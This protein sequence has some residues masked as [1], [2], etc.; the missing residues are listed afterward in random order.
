MSSPL[1]RVAIITPHPW[2]V[3]HPTNDHILDVLEGLADLQVTE[4]DTGVALGVGQSAPQVLIIAPSLR[5]ADR[6]RT[7]A[8][9]RDLAQGKDADETLDRCRD[10]QAFYT[11]VL[12]LGAPINRASVALRAD[13][14]V[15]FERAGISIIH[16]HDPMHGDLARSS[17]RLWDGIVI[18]TLHELPTTGHLQV[19]TAPLRAKLFE[20][21]DACLVPYQDLAGTVSAIAEGALTNVE[22]APTLSATRPALHAHHQGD[23]T[24]ETTTDTTDTP[25][26]PGN[27]HSRA[28]LVPLVNTSLPTDI[29]FLRGRGDDLFLRGVLK[30]L[31]KHPA[32]DAIGN[33][34]LLE[35]W[36]PS[37]RP[38]VPKALRTGVCVDRP[39]TRREADA[40]YAG[41]AAVVNLPGTPLR[42]L[43][44]ARAAGLVELDGVDIDGTLGGI[45]A[46]IAEVATEGPRAPDATLPSAT[47]I[48]FDMVARWAKMAAHR[49]QPSVRAPLGIKQRECFMDL[50]MHTSHSWDCATDPEALMWAARKVGLTG[51]AVTDH[52]EISGALVC[53]EL[54]DE[55]GL[56][57]IV[58][59]EV[60]TSE[61]E[62]I[63][64]FLTERIEGGLT[65]HETIRQIRK[66]DGI[67]YV[68]HPFDRLHTIPSLALL[69]ESIDE[70]DVFEVYNARLAFEQYNRDALKFARRYN[71]LEG[72]GSDA[73]V[74][75][76]LGTAAVQMPA[77]DDPESFLMAL[78]DAEI[79]RR[80]TSVLMLQGLKLLDSVTGKTKAS[81]AAAHSVATHAPL[82][83]DVDTPLESESDPKADPESD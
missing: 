44:E 58:G 35:R 57:V 79:H 45:S 48:A 65:W 66:Q 68:P 30:A 32:S 69:R 31:A 36:T 71:L 61:G 22:V 2:G 47:D 77:W 12:A 23:A 41:S 21:I 83:P 7:R 15:V 1:E 28:G 82:G 75:Q 43:E 39:K 42:L 55:Y 78:R 60:K 38:H 5:T 17:V 63:G 73:H 54:A 6:R 25:D 64:L 37:H 24:D 19:I 18:A 26:T 76:G 13:L 3:P 62:V 20:N 14:R 10:E 70:I 67:V 81:S 9:I 53:A 51:I 52:N 34:R 33:L 40:I 56:Q 49:R 8:A 27:P 50:H 72:A 11:P 29:T 59:E 4:G 46:A 74:M 16:V 80:P